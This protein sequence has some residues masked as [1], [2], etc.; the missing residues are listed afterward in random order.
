M[1]TI[2]YHLREVRKNPW[3][4]EIVP[5]NMKTYQMC[6]SAVEREPLAL[7]HVPARLQTYEM[8]VSAIQRDPVALD[9]VCRKLLSRELCEMT[10]LAWQ[11]TLWGKVSGVAKVKINQNAGKVLEYLLPLT[12]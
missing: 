2:L 9:Y 12:P 8:C 1:E 5:D 4:L 7:E 6:K 10:M 3:H 11:G